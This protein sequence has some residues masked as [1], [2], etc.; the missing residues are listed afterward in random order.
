MNKRKTNAGDFKCTMPPW[1]CNSTWPRQTLQMFPD[2]CGPGHTIPWNTINQG[3]LNLAQG[4]CTLFKPY[5]TITARISSLSF[6]QVSSELLVQGNFKHTQFS[7]EHRYWWDSNSQPLPS[8]A[9]TLSITLTWLLVSCIWHK[10]NW[11]QFYQYNKLI[12][13]DCQKNQQRLSV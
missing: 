8:K 4:S 12:S 13:L 1:L 9:S 6:V 2:H 10:I 3:L 7:W 11:L 5:L